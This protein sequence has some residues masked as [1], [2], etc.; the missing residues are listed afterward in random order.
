MI[1]GFS[2]DPSNH[3]LDVRRTIRAELFYSGGKIDGSLFIGKYTAGTGYS[4]VFVY[5][6]LAELK[7]VKELGTIDN[8]AVVGGYREVNPPLE[9][10]YT[11]D[12]LFGAAF[13]FYKYNNGIP[14]ASKLT[15]HFNL[16]PTVKLS[17]LLSQSAQSAGVTVDTSVLGVAVDAVGL[18]LSTNNASPILQPV[19]VSGA[20][21]L[22]LSISGSGVIHFDIETRVFPYFVFD[23][24]SREL[25]W[26]NIRVLVCKD[27]LTIVP[28]VTSYST[29]IITADG[30]FDGSI[31]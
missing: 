2:H 19:S 31:S 28:I 9:S 4:A 7:R 12:A 20:A 27:D 3:G 1:L 22:S 6:E 5:G 14:D 15:T 10:A 8:Y 23:Y 13:S 11:T 21:N 17:H 30:T 26:A 25:R 18:I 16:F 29:A 24:Q